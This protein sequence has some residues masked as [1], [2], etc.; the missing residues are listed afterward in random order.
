M[1]KHGFDVILSGKLLF[2]FVQQGGDVIHHAIVT[3]TVGVQFIQV[4]GK[5]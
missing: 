4:R 2:N 1:P 5:F 3:A